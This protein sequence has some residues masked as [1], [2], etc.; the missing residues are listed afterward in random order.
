M[1]RDQITNNKTK[2]QKPMISYNM[3]KKFL[4]KGKSHKRHVRNTAAGEPTV[5]LQKRKNIIR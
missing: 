1:S 5:K 4:K 2:Q 3:R